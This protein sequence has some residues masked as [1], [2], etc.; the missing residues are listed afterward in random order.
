[1]AHF[2]AK[3]WGFANLPKKF[4]KIAKPTK[5][6]RLSENADF[7]LCPKFA[8]QFGR[9]R[10]TETFARQACAKSSHFGGL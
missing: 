5:K 2:K 6:W 7:Q 3:A 8:R 9:W 1:M 4:E 10:A